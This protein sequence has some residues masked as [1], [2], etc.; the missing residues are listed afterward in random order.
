[1]FFPPFPFQEVFDMKKIIVI[2]IGILLALACIAA[3][4]VSMYGVGSGNSYR[5]GSAAY[6]ALKSAEVR[7]DGEK[8]IFGD[9]WMEKKD[10]FYVLHLKGTPYETGYQHGA[11][12]R[13]EVNKGAA[14]FY[15]DVIYGGRD[16]PFSLKMWLLRKFLEWKVYVPLEKSQPGSVLEE[17]KGIADGSGV[18]YDVIFR[19]N[20]HTGPSMVLTPVLAKDTLAAFDKAGI[21]VGA[22]STFAA[23][24]KNTAGGRIIVGRNTDYSGVA[25]WPK[26]QTIL[27][28]QPAEGYAHVKI[29]TA[30]VI[31]WNP[32]MNTEGIVVCPHY[33]VFDD[34]DPRG[35]CIAAFTDEILRK[36]KNLDEA[37]KIFAANPRGLSAGYVIISGKEKNAFAAELSTG[38]ATMR[39][40]ENGRVVMTNMAVSEEKRKIDITVRF[41]IMEHCPGRYRRLMKLIDTN[42]G[43][44]DP[45][46]AASFMGDHIQHTTGLERATGHIVGVS[47]NENSMV[48]SPEDLKFWVAAGPAPVCNNPYLGFSLMEGLKGK[49]SAI[50]PGTLRGYAYK[51][52]RIRLGLDEFLK[53]YALREADPDTTGPIIDSLKAAWRIDPYEPHY[54]KLLAKYHLH[55]GRYDDALAVMEKVL[56]LKQSFREQCASA[57]LAGM[58]LDIK[59]ERKKA[60]GYYARI[61][62]LAKAKHDDPWFAMNRVL[63]AFAAKYTKSPFSAENL[64]DQSANIE[65]VDPY[66]E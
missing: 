39:D 46:M 54:G 35:W 16:V 25:L 64:S 22:C 27:Y 36:T 9:A 50:T 44:I 52:R 11:L 24:G 23:T 43:M 62:E 8:R 26:Y 49:A 56:P 45:A 61:G 55:A 66:M 12:L 57:L 3:L 20:H 14:R 30:G 21:K 1:V 42:R 41:N 7:V 65:F 2:C 38:K 19:A 31:L 17:L 53:A 51:D 32:G 34:V 40:M 18:P 60:L 6:S 4:A 15:A 5:P 58:I 10:G 37:R 47:D 13:D 63:Q 33:M 48:F 59:G 28:V 29:G